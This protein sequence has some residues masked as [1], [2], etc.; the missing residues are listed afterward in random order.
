MSRF[1]DVRRD[2]GGHGFFRRVVQLGLQS[3]EQRAGFRSHCV[4]GAFTRRALNLLFGLG[5]QPRHLSGKLRGGID[6]DR[7]RK[8]AYIVLHRFR[9]WCLRS[10][11]FSWYG[12]IFCFGKRL[13]SLGRDGNLQFGRGFG[14]GERKPIARRKSNSPNVSGNFDLHADLKE[15]ADRTRTLNPRDARSDTARL[16]PWFIVGHFERD[17]HV[18]QDVVFRLIAGAVAINDQRRGALLKGTAERVHARNRERHGLHNTCGTPLLGFLFSIMIRFSHKHSPCV[19]PKPITSAFRRRE[20]A[21]R[22]CGNVGQFG[23]RL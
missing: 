23:A 19:G 5:D 12:P 17:P 8:N 6:C 10:G 20:L 4:G 21:N 7:R 14:L 15:L 22:P 16:P 13:R 9:H 18:L 3:G 11:Q 1:F 2:S